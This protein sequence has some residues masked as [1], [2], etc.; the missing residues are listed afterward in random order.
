MHQHAARKADQSKL[1]KTKHGPKM[2]NIKDQGA[3]FEQGSFFILEDPDFRALLRVLSKSPSLA[4]A[5]APT[6]C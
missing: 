2:T 4:L 1:K 3:L 6:C 5:N